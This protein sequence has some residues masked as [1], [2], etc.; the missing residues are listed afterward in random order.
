[1]EN[2]LIWLII[3]A[4]LVVIELFTFIVATFCLA[5]GALLA[6][7]ISLMGL[8]WEAQ[9]ITLA[10]GSVFA[11]V[12][13]APMIRKWQKNKETR[14]GTGTASNMDALLGRVV[15]VMQSIPS[16]GIGRVKV[17]GD[18]WQVVCKDGSEVSAGERVRIVGYDSII[19]EVEKL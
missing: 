7:I 15:E 6:M 18:S 9:L 4:V 11:F 10:I 3:A 17:D 19:L 5:I 8:G 16:H 14:N 12:V 2:W 1:M 13:F